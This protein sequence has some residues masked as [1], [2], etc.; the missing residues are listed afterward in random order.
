LYQPH[1]RAAHGDW[2][3]KTR[4]APPKLRDLARSSSRRLI[5][6]SEKLIGE[7]QAIFAPRSRSLASH[8]AIDLVG[9]T[10]VHCAQSRKATEAAHINQTLAPL[11]GRSSNNFRAGL[12]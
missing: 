9:P 10:E 5:V 11:T 3:G 2:R 7:Q 1:R 12:P 6:L 8:C 4:V